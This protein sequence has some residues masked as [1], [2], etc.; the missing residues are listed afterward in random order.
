MRY[1]NTEKINDLASKAIDELNDLVTLRNPSEIQFMRM[2]ILK[3]IIATWA[4]TM[5]SQSGDR[6]LTLAIAKALSGDDPDEFKRLA[7]V[8]F[9]K[10][11]LGGG[12]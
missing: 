10:K 8:A 5:Q 4:K 1:N 7:K 3:S 11:M 2:H 12:E 9:P 6:A